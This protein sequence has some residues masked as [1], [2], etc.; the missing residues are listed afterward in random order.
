MA[1]E[2]L[3]VSVEVA[4]PPC[5][6]VTLVGLKAQLNPVDGEGDA[7]RATPPL[8][9]FW[10]ATVIVDTPFAPALKLKLET[11]EVNVKS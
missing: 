9:A 3:H 11:L 7:V 2:E 5:V 10:L 1:V 4:L 8:N 6:G